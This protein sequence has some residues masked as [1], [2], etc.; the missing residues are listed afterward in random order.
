[1]KFGTVNLNAVSEGGK[2][3]ALA[4]LYNILVFAV[5]LQQL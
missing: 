5:L 2:F 3:R 4:E 1:L